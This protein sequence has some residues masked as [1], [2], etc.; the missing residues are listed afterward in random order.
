MTD[1]QSNLTPDQDQIASYQRKQQAQRRAAQRPA[2]Q[3]PAGQR[4]AGQRP[5]AK[6]Q[7]QVVQAKTNMPLVILVTLL[8]A[9]LSAVSGWLVMQLL[10]A[11]EAQ[12]TTLAAVAVAE[13][14]IL[15]L[16][17]RLSSSDEDS[18]LSS[19]AIKVMLKEQ[20]GEIR[21]LWDLA[22]KKNR[23]GIASNAK[24]AKAGSKQASANKGAVATL[25][26]NLKKSA[27]EITANSAAISGLEGKVGSQATAQA[28]A[29][30]TQQADITAQMAELKKSVTGAP[31]AIEKRIADNEQGIKAMDSTRLQLNKKMAKVEKGYND[32][33]LEVE[34]L[35]IEIDR[36]KAAMAR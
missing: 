28:K 11:Q 15:A 1:N 21:K 26:S 36:L 10:S 3:R 29:L 33:Q 18:S 35:Q 12:K 24:L 19:A 5:A 16:E 22:N 2:G 31:A 25:S 23:N 9:G 7:V 30:K 6:P 20:D 4:P 34:D 14:K 27:G 32:F 8:F 17:T 13:E